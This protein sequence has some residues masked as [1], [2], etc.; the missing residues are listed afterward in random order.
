MICPSEP[1]LTIPPWFEPTS[2][3]MARGSWGW[4]NGTP[5]DVQDAVFWFQGFGGF[6][7]VPKTM[8][9]FQL[10]GHLCFHHFPSDPG[11]PTFGALVFPS[12]FLP[13]YIF[14]SC[15][16]NQANNLKLSMTTNQDPQTRIVGK[17]PQS[18]WKPYGPGPWLVG[19]TFAKQRF[20]EKRTI[21]V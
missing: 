19:L 9:I 16:I 10:F 12:S 1:M 3:Q 5:K 2:L 8:A 17:V 14:W 6:V 7:E 20:L 21:L 15:V 11:R 18:F 13:G 4:C